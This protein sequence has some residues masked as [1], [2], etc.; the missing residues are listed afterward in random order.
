MPPKKHTFPVIDLTLVNNLGPDLK[1]NIIEIKVALK[2]LSAKCAIVLQRLPE[3]SP[4]HFFIR[5]VANLTRAMQKKLIVPENIADNPIAEF[6][7]FKNL[8]IGHE[9]SGLSGLIE[10]IQGFSATLFALRDILKNLLEDLSGENKENSLH[11]Y[12]L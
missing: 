4:S 1:K 7:Y 3:T 8:V 5:Q 10:K 6:S 2:N 12:Y 9:L 11:V